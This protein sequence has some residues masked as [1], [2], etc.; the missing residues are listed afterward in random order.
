MTGIRVSMV[1]L[2]LT[3]ILVPPWLPE[4]S[5]FT[6]F[7]RFALW[8]IWWPFVTLSPLGVARLWC[9]VFCP[10]GALSAYAARYGSQRPIPSWMRW[11][12]FPLVA[13]TLITLLG[14]LLEVDEAPLPQLLIL[15]GSTILA[16]GI[17]LLYTKRVWAWCRYLC[18]VSLLFG[19]FSRLGV[20]HFRVD[21]ERLR[22]W[23]RE[24]A[25]TDTKQPCPVA[26][27]LPSMTTNR[28]CVMCFRC[29]GWRDSIHLAIRGPAEELLRIHLAQPSRWEVLF[30]FGGAIGLPLGVFHAEEHSLEG[31]HGTAILLAA[32][33]VSLATLSALT[34]L[35]VAMLGVTTSGQFLDARFTCIGYA[36]TPISLFSLFLGLSKPTFEALES[37]G[38]PPTDSDWFRILLLGVGAL[39]SLRIALRILEQLA[40]STV[41]ARLA[42]LPL[43]AGLALILAAWIPL[44]LRS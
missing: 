25:E 12:G 43:T 20:L 30:L 11:G 42:F 37:I 13:F 15:G 7:S 41:R 40:G 24:P 9:G 23:A 6:A 32:M 39:W 29:A 35:S 10:E 14:Q 31:L 4:Q 19:V 1:V 27:H 3:L 36:F 18:P 33:L 8:G 17:G 26:I 2:Y 21:S 16:V 34:R 38:F 44:F 5:R 28:D 22:A